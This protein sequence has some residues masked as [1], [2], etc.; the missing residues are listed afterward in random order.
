[1]KT[2]RLNSI[3][4]SQNFHS[5]TSDKNWKPMGSHCKPK[6]RVRAPRVEKRTCAKLSGTVISSVSPRVQGANS[7]NRMRA[8]EQWRIR[9]KIIVINYIFTSCIWHVNKLYNWHANTT[10]QNLKGLEFSLLARPFTNRRNA[11]LI[12]KSNENHD[13]VLYNVK[14]ITLSSNRPNEEANV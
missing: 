11:R 8:H 5:I 9:L 14:D 3:Q 2:A 4:S 10:A 12:L 6:Q 1:M 13:M 7:V